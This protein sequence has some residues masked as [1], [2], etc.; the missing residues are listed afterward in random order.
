[1]PRVRKLNSVWSMRDHLFRK[2]MQTLR[3]LSLRGLVG[4]V[5][6]KSLDETCWLTTFTVKADAQEEVSAAFAE[7]G[8]TCF[9]SKKEA[10]AGRSSPAWDALVDF[11]ESV[12]ET[13]TVAGLSAI[14]LRPLVAT[15]EITTFHSVV[16]ALVSSS[17]QIRYATQS[18]N[19][20]SIRQ[21]LLDANGQAILARHRFEALEP[22]SE[23]THLANTLRPALEAW[24]AV[25]ADAVG[26]L[27]EIGDAEWKS[28]FRQLK[29]AHYPGAAPE[30]KEIIPPEGLA[31]QGG[32]TEANAET[33]SVPPRNP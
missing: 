5:S 30:T 1:L 16:D 10:L 33:E 12:Y 29:K 11:A 3:T 23:N 8:L 21:W 20:D 22:P 19:A 25:L 7:I 14:D 31:G 17:E 4:A 24:I 6:L 2:A 32:E 28:K 18:T 9:R 26:M 27:W 13:R 15:L